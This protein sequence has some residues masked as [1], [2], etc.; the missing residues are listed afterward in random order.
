[1]GKRITKT[2]MV[3]G[4]ALAVAC[5]NESASAKAIVFEWAT[6]AG[7]TVVELAQN[8]I[9]D[10]T[11][12]LGDKTFG[13]PADLSVAGNTVVNLGN[14][15]TNPSGNGNVTEIAVASNNIVAPQLAINGSN[16]SNL[17]TT[18]NTATGLGNSATS[19]VGNG[20]VTQIALGSGNIINPQVA[21][22]G[23]NHSTNATTTNTAGS[24]GN[25]STVTAVSPLATQVGNG[26]TKQLGVGSGNIW[27][28]QYNVGVPSGPSTQLNSTTANQA[29]G[30]GNGSATKVKAAS[31]ITT[32]TGNGNTQQ[33][34][35][36]TG[37]VYASST[38]VPIATTA[39]STA[40]V[41]TSI[42][43]KPAITVAPSTTVKPAVTTKPAVTV[44]A[45]GGHHK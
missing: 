3:G 43:V 45:G 4:T 35:I 21:V 28:P 26:N 38:P 1:M 44:K 15:G 2:L 10:P 27:N 13:A 41:P 20:N 18:T 40:A 24:N 33:N 12:T 5:I 23:S 7:E 8:N 36:S 6:A 29:I 39:V 22:N 11:L 19:A 17:T 32:Q 34:A 9:V 37:N 25:T 42:T 30:S 14:G 16:N 31:P